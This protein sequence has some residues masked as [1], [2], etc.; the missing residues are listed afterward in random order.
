MDAALQGELLLLLVHLLDEEVPLVSPQDV[1]EGVRILVDLEDFAELL[2][3]VDVGDAELDLVL[4]VHQVSF[5]FL[6]AHEVS[7][8]SDDLQ[9]AAALFVQVVLQ[10]EDLEDLGSLAGDQLVQLPF[11]EELNVVQLILEDLHAFHLLLEEGDFG[12]EVDDVEVDFLEHVLAREVHDVVHDLEDFGFLQVRVQLD[13]VVLHQH[14]PTFL[15]QSDSLLGFV[16]QFDE[17]EV[18]VEDAVDVRYFDLELFEADL[19][20]ADKLVRGDEVELVV[21]EGD[22]GDALH[23]LEAEDLGSGRFQE[24]IWLVFVF[25]LGKLSLCREHQVLVLKP[26][27]LKFHLDDLLFGLYLQG[28]VVILAHNRSKEYYLIDF[29]ERSLVRKNKF[30]SILADFAF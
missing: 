11:L 20:L 19:E 29:F 18:V 25:I 16:I 30:N 17:V 23:D 8:T 6:F 1:G 15:L 3:F 22:L 26:L 2:L 14:F 28:Q 5:A 27:K 12:G 13:D 24:I 9:G 10:V 21:V 7:S 4:C